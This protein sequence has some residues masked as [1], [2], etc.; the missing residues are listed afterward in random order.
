MASVSLT[1]GMEIMMELEMNELSDISDEI[2]RETCQTAVLNKVSQ[3]SDDI[4]SVAEGCVN[5]KY[6]EWDVRI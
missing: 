3:N 5:S 6:G 1:T 4:A 2:I